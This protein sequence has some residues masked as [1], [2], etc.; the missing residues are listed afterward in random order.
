[1]SQS[2]RIRHILLRLVACETKHH[3]L[4]TGTDGVQL[5]LRHRVLL[6]FQSL[7]NP[8]GDIRGLFVQGYDHPAGI[9]VKAV[10]GPVI[11]N[12]AN[13][14]ANHLLDVYIC[15]SSHLTHHQHKSCGTA[16]L[17]GHTAHRVLL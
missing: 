5:C 4:V 7:V 8:H 9:T 12:L 2:D 16:R 1:M 10:F 6:C 13:G 14:F 3:P 11:A 15:V 17:T